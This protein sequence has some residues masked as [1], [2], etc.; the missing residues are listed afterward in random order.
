MQSAEAVSLKITQLK[1]TSPLI[2]SERVKEKTKK[3]VKKISFF[4]SKSF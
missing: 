1:K 3:K 4:L 2:K